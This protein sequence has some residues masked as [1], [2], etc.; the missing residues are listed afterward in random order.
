M[1]GAAAALEGNFG[2]RPPSPNPFAAV[3]VES[4]A[5]IPVPDLRGCG[6]GGGG[7]CAPPMP[8]P[9][10][11]AAAVLT[12]LGGGGNSVCT[13]II[14]RGGM[15]IEFGLPFCPCPTLGLVEGEE[16]RC[17]G[18]FATGGACFLE[19]EFMEAALLGRLESWFAG[20][21]AT[22]LFLVT[23]MRLVLLVGNVLGSNCGGSLR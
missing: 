10:C 4:L 19:I 6:G 21:P 11:P 1:C 9:S 23:L 15:V 13:P 5:T 3:G 8:K 18:F 14:D 7:V 16:V 20:V 17:T 2:P 12:L 22:E